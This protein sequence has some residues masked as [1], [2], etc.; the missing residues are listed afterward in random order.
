MH[1]VLYTF[2]KA[3][4]GQKAPGDGCDAATDEGHF[5]PVV[6]AHEHRRLLVA[7]EHADVSRMSTD[8]D[9]HSERVDVVAPFT[10][11]QQLNCTLLDKHDFYN[12]SANYIRCLKKL[13][14]VINHKSYLL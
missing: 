5:E 2:D 13:M 8:E 6:V 10:V 11:H 9:G 3:V 7:T 4:F 14:F 1:I 12:R